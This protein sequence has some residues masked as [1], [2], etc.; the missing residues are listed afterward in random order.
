MPS[1]ERRAVSCAERSQTLCVAWLLAA[2]E[3]RRWRLSYRHD[4]NPGKPQQHLAVR[5]R[6]VA[7]RDAGG[8]FGEILLAV[9]RIQRIDER[10]QACPLDPFDDRRGIVEHMIIDRVPYLQPG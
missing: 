5:L 2:R 7:G 8:V 9:R 1:S 3:R 10:P 4:E 6:R